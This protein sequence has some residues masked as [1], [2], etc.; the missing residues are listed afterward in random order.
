MPVAKKPTKPKKPSGFSVKTVEKCCCQV[1]KYSKTGRINT[2]V[3]LRMRSYAKYADIDKDIEIDTDTDIVTDI[4]T[5]IEIETE[6]ETDIN[7]N[8]EKEIEKQLT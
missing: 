8:T 2:K 4:V 3:C 1:K 6:T 7:I 5:G